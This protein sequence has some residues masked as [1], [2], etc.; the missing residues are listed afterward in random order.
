VEFGH[1]LNGHLGH[2]PP[3]YSTF[4]TLPE[5]VGTD[6]GGGLIGELHRLW[7]IRPEPEDL[8]YWQVAGDRIGYPFFVTIIPF[9]K[10]TSQ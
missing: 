6:R 8:G 10:R 9:L 1:R 7:K 2:V 5:S 3:E 4:K